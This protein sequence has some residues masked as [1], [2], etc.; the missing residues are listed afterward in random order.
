[1]AVPSVSRSLGGQVPTRCCSILPSLSDHIAARVRA[2]E[3]DALHDRA[4]KP[5]LWRA[6]RTAAV[7]WNRAGDRRPLDSEIFAQPAIRAD[8][9][10]TRLAE[11]AHQLPLA[12]KA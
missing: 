5:K 1:M 6:S 4:F 11:Q 2:H 12:E 8:G 9:A 7:V 3:P 10:C